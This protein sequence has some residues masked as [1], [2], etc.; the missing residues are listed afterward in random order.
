MKKL[1]LLLSLVPSVAVAEPITWS[2]AHRIN[3]PAANLPHDQPITARLMG[4]CITTDPLYVKGTTVGASYAVLRFTVEAAD[5]CI[6][7]A[8]GSFI[9]R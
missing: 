1:S 4:R 8:R 6:H 9:A 5:K 3:A 2:E 7:Y